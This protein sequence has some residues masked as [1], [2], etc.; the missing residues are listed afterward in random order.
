MGKRLDSAVAVR[1]VK[2]QGRHPVGETL[3]LMVWPSGRKTWV[4]RLTI[5][6]KRKDRG[7]GSYPVVS[8]A[9]AREM[10]QGNLALARSGSDPL[11]PQQGAEAAAPAVPT[12]ED[13]ARQHIDEH[14]GS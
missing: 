11:A 14:L 13:L 1:N 7:L 4:Q 5:K 8:L 9:Q 10:A 3:Y 6:G 2:T 12:F